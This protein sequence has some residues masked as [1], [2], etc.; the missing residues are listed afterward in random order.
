MNFFNKTQEEIELERKE[1]VSQQQR[2]DFFN[3][4]YKQNVEN[5]QYISY[6]KKKKTKKKK[7]KLIF[8]FF[9]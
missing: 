1:F 6:G 2:F 8:F 9:F 5:S 3:D 4:N 7:K